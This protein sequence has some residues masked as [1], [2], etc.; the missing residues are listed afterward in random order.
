MT[1]SEGSA[2]TLQPDVSENGSTGWM[3]R[4]SPVRR[5]DPTPNPVVN[6]NGTFTDS[7]NGFLRPLLR[8]RNRHVRQDPA[9]DDADDDPAWRHA[10]NLGPSSPR[11]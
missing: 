8:L 9:H 5:S 10:A 6:W 11:P 2:T 7:A 1:E 4:L 3:F